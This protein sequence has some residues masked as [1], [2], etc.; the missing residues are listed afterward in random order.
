[1]TGEIGRYWRN[2]GEMPRRLRMLCRGAMIGGPIL[3]LFVLAPI[4]DWDVNGKA[5]SY[6]EFWRSG[7]GLSALCF[8][9]LITVG[10]WGLAARIG[11]SRWALVAAPILPIA[12]FPKS[13]VPDLG[14]AIASGF[15]TAV[16]TYGCLFHLQSVCDY[17]RDEQG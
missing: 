4:R 6:G 3:L 14:L 2:S 7:A 11:W 16:M 13:L 1:M 15:V 9:G 5:M 17:L 8:V 12:F 10:V